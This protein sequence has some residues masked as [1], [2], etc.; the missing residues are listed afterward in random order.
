MGGGEVKKQK[1]G[2]DTKVKY[3]SKYQWD[4]TATISTASSLAK[5][6]ELLANANRTYS[7]GEDKKNKCY[8]GKPTIAVGRVHAKA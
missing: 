5:K 6:A 1:R 8:N 3:T 2:L 7:N 4:I